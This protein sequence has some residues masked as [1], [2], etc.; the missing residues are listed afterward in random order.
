MS[1]Q[2][3][4]LGSQPV[5]KRTIRRARAIGGVYEWVVPRITLQGRALADA[6]FVPGCTVLV[7]SPRPGSL[8]I[9]RADLTT[10]LDAKPTRRAS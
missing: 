10:A 4:F 1:S 7:T 5:S 2:P 6:G 9:Q 3:K 8:V